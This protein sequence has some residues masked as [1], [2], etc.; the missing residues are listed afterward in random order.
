MMKKSV[1]LSRV[2]DILM[3]EVSRKWTASCTLEL[4]R[5]QN[6]RL[7]IG[8]EFTSTLVTWSFS[9]LVFTTALVWIQASIS[10]PYACSKFVADS[11]LVRWCK[12]WQSM[13]YHQDEPKWTA[14]YRSNE[15]D[16]SEV[17]QEYLKMFAWELLS[18]SLQSKRVAT[19]IQVWEGGAYRSIVFV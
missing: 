19:N 7:T 6:S 10:R 15:T 17:R 14:H 8:S 5:D 11:V 12:C 2:V 1:I 16:Q 13:Y 3:S 4:T 18:L 9:Q